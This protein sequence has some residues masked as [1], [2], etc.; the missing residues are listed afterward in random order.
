LAYPLKLASQY[1][2][3]SVLLDESLKPQNTLTV[4][5]NYDLEVYNNIDQNVPTF[6]QLVNRQI[7]EAQESI[8]IAIYSFNIDSIRTSLFQ[9]A[10]RGVDVHL[11]Y[12]RDMKES[13]EPFLGFALPA[14]NVSYVGTEKSG[15]EE[16]DYY[17]MHHK[18]IIVDPGT[19]KEVLLTG[20]WNWSYFQQDSDPNILLQIKDP[21]IID[22]YFNEFKRLEKGNE[23]VNKFNDW[24]YIPWEKKITY[25]NGDSVEIWWSPGRMKN[26]VFNKII[27]LMENAEEKIDVGITLIDSKLIA[28]K[29][30]EKAKEGVAV[31]IIVDT[32][33][34]NRGEAIIPWMREK[35]AAENIQNIEI[36]EG[37]EKPAEDTQIYAIFHHQNMIVD[38]KIVL[39][40]TANWTSGGFVRNDE[41]T[42]IFYSE[43][44]AMQFEAIFEKYLTRLTKQNVR[45]FTNLEY[46][47]TKGSVKCE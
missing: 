31:R 24:N 1:L 29:L 4:D 27:E 8:Y 35:I 13:L 45:S 14:F 23:G 36:F 22:S 20:P 7:D 42:L 37:G 46:I 32:N 25:A 15:E 5:Y 6:S 2:S 11:V 44:T 40:G 30:I 38:N 12:N 34:I 47:L 10:F 43:K 18:F 9:A 17:N 33:Q 19:E 3:S 28:K 39:T 41:N 16:E 26:S 21:E